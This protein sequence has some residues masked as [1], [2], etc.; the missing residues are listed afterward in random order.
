MMHAEPAR[1]RRTGPL[2]RACG[3][4]MAFVQALRTNAFVV[5]PEQATSF[6]A[7]VAL[8]GPRSMEHIHQAAIA[9]LAPP[10]ERRGAFDALFRAVFFADAPLAAAGD[11]EDEETRIRDAGGRDERREIPLKR[12]K[13]GAISSTTEQL[14]VRNFATGED[15]AL[16]AFR[17]SL[18]RALPVRRT[19]RQLKALSGGS[20]DLRRS[21]REI[22][23]G[24]GD[25][26]SPDYRRRQP[27]PRRLVLLIDISGSM[28]EHTEA[29]L[30]LAHATVQATATAEVF[31]IGTRLTRITRALRI[32]D[33][34]RALALAADT[35][36][37]WD[38]GTRIGPALLAFLAVPRFAALSRG[39]SV[40]V[41]SD[42]LERGDHTALETAM[43]RLSA[44]AFRLS[45]ASPLA[46]DP[47]FRPET[48]A[49]AAILPFL[50]DLVDG[51]SVPA[52]TDFLLSLGR[53]APRAETIWGRRKH[54][55][56]R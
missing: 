41:L 4:F 9:T 24:D 20:I 45:L 17:R 10:P 36:A 46:G 13:G 16:S 33:R 11:D 29:H 53:P 1:R 54:E 32:R 5:A 35:V 42:G 34:E 47:R 28:R 48:A 19:F 56:H 2:P 31:T 43:R 18:A 38:G 40:V 23:R 37:D 25:V 8:V 55:R 51:A 3:P 12:E 50:D 27:V 15:A 26:P 14:S 22:V 6:L 52:L 39:A 7:A 30:R 21:M 44:R 49:L